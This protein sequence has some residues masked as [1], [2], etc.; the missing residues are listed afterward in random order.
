MEIQNAE[1]FME[2]F[3]KDFQKYLTPENTFW[4]NTK[5]VTSSDLSV[6]VPQYLTTIAGPTD[7][8]STDAL[9]VNI[10]SESNKVITQKRF[11]S[12]AY[13]IDD[14]VEFF[15]SQS[16][17]MDAIGAIK[18]FID[19]AIGNYAAYQFASQKAAT[20]VFTSGTATRTSSVVGSTATVKRIVEA[21]MLKVRTLI[22]KSN[23]SG[24]WFGLVSA[25]QMEDLLSITNI[26]TA[27]KTGL[28]ESS[29]LTGRIVTVLG[30]TIFERNPSLGANVAYEVSGTTATI[31]NIYNVPGAAT[32]A[33]TTASRG[34]AIFWNEKALYSNKGLMKTY[35]NG[36]DAVYQG[37]ILSTN[38][39]FG[40]DKIRTDEVG[41][42]SLI[43]QA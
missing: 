11:R 5:G 32:G 36:S 2:R 13:Q 14:Y 7:P 37:D 8:T 24:K 9:N 43:E 41:V 10:W 15:T 30:I 34:A 26:V 1:K 25:D 17:K 21:D 22:G 29:F 23:M 4:M 27:D 16:L 39:A 28:N 33:T 6:N 12:Q 35:V 31:N 3:E 42:I 18:D 38:Y 40:V 19:T 20:Q